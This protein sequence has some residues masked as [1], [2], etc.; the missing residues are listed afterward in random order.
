[1]GAGIPVRVNQLS[2][3][4]FRGREMTCDFGE[5]KN[6]AVEKMEWDGGDY[7]EWF[8]LCDE[9]NSMECIERLIEI[10]RGAYASE[11]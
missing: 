1:V 4:F 9:H 10:Q 11:K 6:E 2:P 7:S 3:E 5:C 8:W